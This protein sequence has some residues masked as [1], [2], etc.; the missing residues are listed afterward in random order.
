MREV[1]RQA[2]KNAAMHS[3]NEERNVCHHRF[4]MWRLINIV[5]VGLSDSQGSAAFTPSNW[6]SSTAVQPR[7][8]AEVTP[9]AA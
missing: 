1:D 4:H 6:L 3:E 7:L 8:S 5:E 2:S 9:H